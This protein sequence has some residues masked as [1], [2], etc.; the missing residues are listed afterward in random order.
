MTCSL[1]SFSLPSVFTFGGLF[2]FVFVSSTHLGL[3]PFLNPRI[4]GKNL[5]NKRFSKC[6]KVCYIT[7]NSSS[8]K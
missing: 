1:Q 5:S 6:P 2:L 3:L 8:D 7:H 4:C